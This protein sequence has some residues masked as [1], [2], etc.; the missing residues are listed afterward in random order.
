MK[1][2][3][4]NYHCPRTEQVALDLI[5]TLENARVLAGGQSLVPML[6][7]RYAAVDHLI[8]INRIE[9]LAGIAETQGTITIGAMTRQARL[10]TDGRLL[11]CCPIIAEAME[12]VGHIPTRARGTI[13]GS[14]AHMDPA[15]ELMGIASVYDATIEA[16][17]LKGSRSISIHDFPAA[18]MTPTLRSDEMLKS[19]TFKPWGPGHG[20]AFEEFAQ[21]RG[22]F[23]IVGVAVLL[24]LATDVVIQRAA[25][26]LI[27][28]DIAPVRLREAEAALVGQRATSATL[29]EAA[30]ITQSLEPVS[31]TMASTSYRKRLARALTLRA[32]NRAAVRGGMVETA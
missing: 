27:G 10:A 7:F 17:S 25:I 15:A 5:S 9:S 4:F 32:L 12:Y 14:L 16:A 29:R 13:G 3:P 26:A 18:Y 2:P 24:E 20:F 21:R 11:A 28:I 31:D 30:E 23:A 6:N 19:V 22:D 1:A 8:D